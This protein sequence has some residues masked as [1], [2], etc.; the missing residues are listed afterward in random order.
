MITVNG[1]FLTQRITGAQRYGHE[2]VRRLAA[3]NTNN[4]RILMPRYRGAIPDELLAATR[5]VGRLKGHPWEQIELGRYA[6]K[7]GGV[8]WSPVNVG[9]ISARCQVVTIH[10]VFSIEFPD[11][12]GRRFHL[13][14]SLL[15]PRVVSSA[16]HLL[17]VSEYSKSRIVETLDVP[18]SKVS[19]VYPGVDA[20]FAISGQDQLSRIRS[21]YNLPEEFIL[22]LGSLEP[23]K[24]LHQVVDAWLQ[25]DGDER[26][27]L[28]IAGGLGAQK[29]FGSYDASEL[30]RHRDIQLLGYVPDEDLAALY[31]A[32]RVFVYASLLEGFGL[33]PLEAMACGAS[34]VLSDTSAMRETH[35]GMAFV[36]DPN[37]TESIAGGMLQA[38]RDEQTPAGRE[39]QSEMIKERFDWAGTA[40]QVG[41][42]LQRYE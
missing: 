35:G 11:W 23:R 27:P 41:E 1:R 39:R 31:G 21:K 30:Q 20:N 36:V 3:R 22:T 26:P 7:E 12:V 29:V 40:N 33:P 2:I 10:D 32:A 24:N 4:L 18:E 37:D 13:W 6:N 16:R 15:L 25:L 38:L 42:I 19:V 14:Y 5:Q 28:V 17:T 34:V 9:P 8:L